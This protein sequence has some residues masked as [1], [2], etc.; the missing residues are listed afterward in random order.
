[1]HQEAWEKLEKVR[2]Y[3]QDKREIG[4]ERM[5]QLLSN[6]QA[7]KAELA[8]IIF[9]YEHP[10]VVIKQEGRFERNIDLLGTINRY[11][12]EELWNLEYDAQDPFQDF[13]FT[14][15]GEMVSE[16]IKTWFVDCFQQAQAQ[17]P[18]EV[19]LY[20]KEMHDQMEILELNT[21]ETWWEK[22]EF[23]TY[24]KNNRARQIELLG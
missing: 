22:N 12:M 10:E 17:S 4:V 6:L 24:V 5:T 11:E 2:T 18:I 16:C 3:L 7:S 14:Q 23:E 1:M 20:Y 15:L 19:S 9:T 8:V 21:L 13:A